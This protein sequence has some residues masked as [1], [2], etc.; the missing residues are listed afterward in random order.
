MKKSDVLRVWGSVLRG[1][2]PFLS[3]EIT[4]ECPL[5]CPGCYAYSPEHPGPGAT[6]R[7]LSDYRGPELVETVLT[8]VRRMRPVHLSI[9]GG[10]PLVRYRELCELL[11]ALDRMGI[12]V[13]LVTSAV[14]PIPQERSAIASLRLVVSIDGLA[15][16]HNQRRAPATYDRI[17]KHIAGQ[18]IAVHCTVTRQM[19][20]RRG[21]LAEFSTFWSG[22]PEVR[23]I[24]FSIYTPQE[25]DCSMERLRSQDREV[26]FEELAAAARFPKVDLPGM[27]LQG[28]RNPPLSPRQCAFARLSTCISADVKTRI[29][30]CEFSGAPVCAECGCMA[31]AGMG[32]VVEAPGRIDSPLRNPRRFRVDR[33][34]SPARLRANAGK[35]LNVRKTSLRCIKTMPTAACLLPLRLGDQIR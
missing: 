6:L 3:I 28:Y 16:E 7:Q 9:V 20:E 29:G 14:R 1:N 23:K 24:W 10:E 12:E 13:Q 11:P 31:S 26:L 17:L 30:P 8:L 18:R 34:A 22:Q 21:Y 2:A 35:A 5:R 33:P 19:I 4:K 25:G 15:P 32:G 27:V